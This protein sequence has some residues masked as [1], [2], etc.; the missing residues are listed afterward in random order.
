MT[1]FKNGMMFGR[2]RVI[3]EGP[4][5]DDGRRQIWCECTCD[6]HTVILVSAKHLTSG[7]TRS[8]GCLQ[9]EAVANRNRTHGLR[10]HPLYGTHK[11]FKH[12]GLEVY[13]AWTGPNGLSEFIK[14]AENNGYEPGMQLHRKDTTRGILPDNLYFKKV[15]QPHKEVVKRKTNDTELLDEKFGK[16]TVIAYAGS[17][18]R[19]DGQMSRYWLCECSCQYAGRVVVSTEKLRSGA[20]KDCGCESAKKVLSRKYRDDTTEGILNTCDEY[21]SLPSDVRYET[22]KRLWEIHRKMMNR[23][24]DVND[25]AYERYGGR[26][27][28]VCDKWAN[29]YTGLGNF[30]VWALQNGYTQLL[31][32][33]RID[34]DKGYEPSNCRWATYA[35]QANNKKNNALIYD[36]EEWL[37][38]SELET[39]YHKTEGYYDSHITRGWSVNAIVHDCVCNNKDI[40]HVDGNY[41]CN[42]MLELIPR[43][44]ENE[45]SQEEKLALRAKDIKR[46]K[47]KKIRH[48][49]RTYQEYLLY[50]KRN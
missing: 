11:M 8:C 24:N 1:D 46:G 47:P 48:P 30:I 9:R 22:Y 26:G 14:W 10:H 20:V 25:D 42:G 41:Y 50:T 33:D 31:T 43:I 7:N 16:L 35:E 34:N 23:C 15:K 38:A 39:K 49:P 27:I 29:I 3:G 32:I 36:G 37:T 45:L 28:K 4:K 2:L 6:D 12:R 18:P 5:D 44:P 13:E 17:R 19:S 21:V 40:R